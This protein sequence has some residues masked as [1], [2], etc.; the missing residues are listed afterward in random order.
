MSSISAKQKQPADVAWQDEQID[1]DS[2]PMKR[3][4]STAKGESTGKATN[5]AIVV[6]SD[7]SDEQVTSIRAAPT[8]GT[9]LLS[10]MINRASTSKAASAPQSTS[11]SGVAKWKQD[12]YELVEKY[13]SDKWVCEGYVGMEGTFSSKSSFRL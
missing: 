4:K 5:A 11:S 6:G 9:G 1:I 2:R 8:K 10:G 3:V 7:S 13:G 12:A